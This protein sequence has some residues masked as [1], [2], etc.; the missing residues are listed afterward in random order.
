MAKPRD[1]AYIATKKIDLAALM[2]SDDMMMAATMLAAIDWLMTEVTA[3]MEA[4][5]ASP[6]PDLMP[7]LTITFES[8]GGPH[9]GRKDRESDRAAD[10]W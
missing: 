9:H 1:T 5:H 10:D 3:K 7:E 6:N 4:D 2:K 8:R